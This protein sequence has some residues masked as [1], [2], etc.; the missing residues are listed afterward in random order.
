MTK[1]KQKYTF[2]DTTPFI[3]ARKEVLRQ[4]ETDEFIAYEGMCF[5][6][7]MTGK[8]CGEYFIIIILVTT[9]KCIV[10]TVRSGVHYSLTQM[11]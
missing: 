4:N 3:Y 8:L 6:A 10:N 5:A 1:Y 11:M 7:H 2:G 9:K